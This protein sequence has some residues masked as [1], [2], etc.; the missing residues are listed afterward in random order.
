M[1]VDGVNALL[2]KVLHWK[3]LARG[4]YDSLDPA[5]SSYLD[6]MAAIRFR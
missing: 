1:G 5:K 2:M 3:N 4:H 6:L